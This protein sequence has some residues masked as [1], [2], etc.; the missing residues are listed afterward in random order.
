MFPEALIKAARDGDLTAM[1]LIE[2]QLDEGTQ[3]KSYKKS[4][5]R[6][7]A[8]D[9]LASDEM[10][11]AIL[12]Q[13]KRNPDII[14]DAMLLRLAKKNASNL[15]PEKAAQTVA[16]IRAKLKANPELFSTV[17]EEKIMRMIPERLTDVVTPEFMD[18]YPSLYGSVKN[19]FDSRQGIMAL[20]GAAPVLDVESPPRLL[21]MTLTRM[22][23]LM[24]QLPAKELER[25]DVPT[26]LNKVIQLD[27]VRNE[28]AGYANQAEKL[29]SAG[30]VVPEKVTTY[31]TK[32]FTAADAQGFMWREITEPDA[33]TIQ[34]KLL[35]HSI[36][37]Y[38]RPGSY[39][40]LSKGRTAI[41]NG[42]VRLFGLYDKN[43]QLMTNVEYVTNKA[44]TLKNSIPQFYGNGPATGNVVPDKFVPQVEE[45]INKLN[46]DNI[47][48]SIKQLLRDSGISF[49]K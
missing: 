2:K 6:D 3:I 27:K 7:Y 17:Y 12:Q 46:P 26:M 23:E 39:G 11:S 40:S 10:R 4:D 22:H 29:I 8:S 16:D 36:G 5:T 34:S 30:E 44:E 49:T 38:A 31:G 19:I 45:L 32:P 42:E 18:K 28:V 24:Q 41:D 1:K 15:S 33:A 37:G 25:M 14:P 13:M 43:N 9:M 20:K 35:G 47:P 21:G 48:P